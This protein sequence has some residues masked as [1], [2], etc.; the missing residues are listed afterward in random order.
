[1]AGRADH[2]DLSRCRA[3]V[4]VGMTVGVA[5][6]P[7]DGADAETLLQHADTALYH[8][9]RS[10]RPQSLRAWWPATAVERGCAVSA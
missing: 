6:F 9:K 3:S 4:R 8:G 2:G 10:R 5:R 1:M 7:L